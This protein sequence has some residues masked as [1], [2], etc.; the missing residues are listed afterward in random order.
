MK[1][2][3]YPTLGETWLAI[4][5][6]VYRKG[7]IA[8]GETREL[9]HVSASFKTGEFHSDPLLVRFASLRHVEEMRKTFFS[10]EPSLFK[11][12]YSERMRGPLGCS[13]L[14]D[15]IEL[16][17]RSPW[18][19]R[20]VVTLTSHGDGQ[21]PC[22][23]AIH[24]LRRRGGLIAMYFARGQDIFHKFYADG[25]C[26]YEMAKRVASG[27]DIPLLMISGFISS[28]HVYIEDTVEIENL[29]DEAGFLQQATALRGISA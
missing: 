9:L 23:N 29:L 4:L 10:E 3:R 2:F 5:H 28:A 12:N 14:S 8:G 16:L 15:V 18:S 27:L 13:D 25:V 24:F 17:Y 19:K 6:A 22:I 11:H 20:A 1:Q 21:V 7:E 26:I